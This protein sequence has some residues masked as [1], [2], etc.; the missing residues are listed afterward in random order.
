MNAKEFRDW[1]LFG[2]AILMPIITAAITWTKLTGK[3]NGLGG[4]L[5]RNEDACAGT[6]GR[7]DSVE[8]QLAEVRAQGND[9]HTRLG[10]VEGKVDGVDAHVTEMKL[11][12]FQ[13]LG[14]IKGLITTTNADLRQFIN[15][16]DTNLRERVARIEE[17]KDIPHKER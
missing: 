7:L 1:V 8:R 12:L 14:D 6:G 4:R 17:R 10:K 11:E 9:V 5:K 13:H 16:K 2:F 3:V 15:D